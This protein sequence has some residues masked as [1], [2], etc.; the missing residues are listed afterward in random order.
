[1]A[2]YSFG[3]K[4]GIGVRVAS[5][6]LRDRASAASAAGAG[7]RVATGP[8]SPPDPGRAP[9]PVAGKMPGA[10]QK[11]RN[12][13]RASKR[14]GEAIWGPFARISGVLWLEVTG[15]FFG[16][17]ALFFAQNVY[18]LRHQFTTGGEHGKLWIY[19]SLTAIFAYFTFTSFYRARRK[20][21]R[22]GQ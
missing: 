22:A 19:A 8:F 2:P 17:F 18:R 11:T 3:R 16:I 9:S 10:A 1:M 7:A 4:L 13:G 15:L 20:A 14:F 21:K 12:I 6:I 5:Q